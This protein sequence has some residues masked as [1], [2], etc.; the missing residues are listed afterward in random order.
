[1]DNQI[2]VSVIIAVYNEEDYIE[3]CLDSV[4]HQTLNEI[5]II[6][7]DDGSTDNT[8]SILKRYKQKDSRIKIISQK[9]QYAG[10]ARNNGMKQAQGKYLAFLDADDYYSLDMLEKLYRSAEEQNMEVVICEYNCFDSISNKR[11]IKHFER[12]EALLG[13]STFFSGSALKHAAIFQITKGWAWDK[14]FLTEYVKYTG[15]KFQEFRSSED[16]FFVYMLLARAQRI[17]FVK[18]K[19]AVH[20]IRNGKSLSNTMDENWIN[21]YTMLFSIKKE[22]EQQKL[23]QRFQQSFL[24]FALEFQIYYLGAM[25]SFHALKK[26]F[27]YTKEQAEPV[28]HILT[29]PDKEQF[30]KC[31][32]EEYQRIIDSSFEE[33][34][35]YHWTQQNAEIQNFKMQGWTFTYNLIEKNKVVILYGAGTIGQDYYSQLSKS[36]Y[37]KEL[38]VVDRCFKDYT[39]CEFLVQDPE[40][41]FQMSFDYIII[42]IKNKKIQK[43][44]REWL[45]ERGIRLE[46]IRCFG[47]VYEDTSSICDRQ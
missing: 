1:M 25:S 17:G 7:V 21:G 40:N 24:V 46:A 22:L 41:I 16:G 2:K 43:K 10:V 30:E 12:E 26:C 20:R 8:V 47:Q 32:Y 14:L 34:L 18:E 5:E 31:Y 27:H 29:Y 6:C 3:Q 36:G 23:Y 11:I 39:E 9:N 45:C 35:F 37:C 19:L 42:T 28:F 4:C 15:Y 33:Y 38:I 44:V 13:N